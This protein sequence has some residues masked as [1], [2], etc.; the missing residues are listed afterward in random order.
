MLLP[1]FCASARL[2]AIVDIVK[3][4]DIPSADAIEAQLTLWM[5]KC[6]QI[7]EKDRP[8]CALQALGM[9]DLNIF[10]NI[11]GLLS[12]LATLPVLT[13]TLEQTFSTLR[14]L[15]SYFLNCMNQD[16][17]TGLALLSIHREI[18]VGRGPHR[19]WQVAVKEELPRLNCSQCFKSQLQASP[20]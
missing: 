16:R 1:K 17:L 7:E 3:L 12:I 15:E 18:Q 5:S 20:N 19:L 8:G 13:S 9:C 11:H 6:C 14:R 10:P 4:S 2:S